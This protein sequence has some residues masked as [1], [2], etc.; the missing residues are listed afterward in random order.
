MWG[1]YTSVRVHGADP[2]S[3]VAS[4]FT[5]EGGTAR[6]D[7]VTRYLEF[8]EGAVVPTTQVTVQV[9]N[10]GDRIGDGDTKWVRATVTINGT[11]ADNQSVDFATASA[12]L[13]VAPATV[14]TNAQGI[15]EATLTSHAGWSDR[16]TVGVTATANGETSSPADVLVP[17]VSIIGL[18]LLLATMILLGL[19]WRRRMAG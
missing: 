12:L 14:S 15:A 18:I 17:D 2:Q 9:E 1:D 10:P 7:I 8:S 11:P 19:Y 3:W 5:L 4:G 13:T 16:D 6:Q